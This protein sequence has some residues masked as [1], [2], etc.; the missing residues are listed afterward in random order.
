MS[1]NEYQMPICNY[2]L[3]GLNHCFL[4]VGRR[5]MEGL[6]AENGFWNELQGISMVGTYFILFPIFSH[7][8]HPFMSNFIFRHLS[9]LCWDSEL[10]SRLWLQHD[11]NSSLWMAPPKLHA[12]LFTASRKFEARHF[13]VAVWH[14]DSMLVGEECLL[15]AVQG[16]NDVLLQ[17]IDGIFL[18]DSPAGWAASD[19]GGNNHGHGVEKGEATFLA[20]ALLILLCRIFASLLLG[21]FTSFQKRAWMMGTCQSTRS[22]PVYHHKIQ[23]IWCRHI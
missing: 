17:W 5:K 12:L 21:H 15:D 4:P 14:L 13:S 8:F 16:V 18:G 10:F 19:D 2:T 9:L 6:K 7:L 1:V 20:A 11:C 3:L 22:L 23:R